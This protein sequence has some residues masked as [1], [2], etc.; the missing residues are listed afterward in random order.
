MRH[1]LALLPLL[2]GC[3]LFKLAAIEKGHPSEVGELTVAGL[4]DTVVI[5][6]DSLG[7]PH[8][9]AATAD[10]AI[11]GLGFVHAQDRLFQADLRRRL[12]WGQLSPWLGEDLA[13][14]DLFNQ[15]LELRDRAQRSI[16]ALPAEDRASVEAYVAGFNAGAASL[17]ALPIEYRLL[18]IDFEEWTAADTLSTPFLQ[19]WNLAENPS[20]E[21]FAYLNRAVL[22]AADAE[23]LFRHSLEGVPTEASWDDLRARDLPG[24]SEGYLSYTS[25]VGGMPSDPAGAQASNSWVIGPDKSAD[26]KPIV[27]NDPHLGQGVPSLWY[28]ADIKGGD[29]HVAGVTL[30]GVPGVVIGHNGKIAWGLTN[31]MADTVDLAVLERKGDQVVVDGVAETPRVVSTSAAGQTG[32]THWTSLGPIVSAPDPD[33]AVVLQWHALGIED[34]AFVAWGELNRATSVSDALAA[35]EGRTLSVAQNLVVGDVDGDFGWQQVGSV[36]ERE[37]HSGRVPHDGSSGDARWVG[38]H[39]DLPGERAPD[40][41][42][43]ITANARP[44]IGQTDF[45]AFNVP[46]WRHSRIHQLLTAGEDLTSADMTAIQMDIV[47]NQARTYLPGL[48]HEVSP[49]TP[50]ATTCHG[51]L[52]DWDGVMAT[53]S[54]GAAAWAAYQRELARLAAQAHFGPESADQLVS[55]MSSGRNLLDG[56]WDR[57]APD[58]TATSEAALDAACTWLTEKL[59]DD[60]EAWRWGDLH[61]LRLQHPFARSSKL[62]SKW[63]MAEVPWPG[64]GS[65]VAAAGYSWR[66]DDWKVGGMVSMRLVMPLGD[67][68][69]STLV[70][71]GGQSGHPRHPTYASH[72]EAFTT[73]EVLPLWF[74]DEDVIAETK[75]TLVLRPGG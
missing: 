22:S 26:G 29:L 21:A 51:L 19:S 14:L 2:T 28:A 47:D 69:A 71:P 41:G 63:N 36:V 30:A 23:A 56:D 54:A 25:A 15:G 45:G 43:I 42:F 13:T 59:G 66:R 32:E 9:R 61:P 75:A 27:A 10:D 1:T 11:Y 35:F 58:R 40:R 46:A 20:T 12:A 48:L 74:E 8:I 64:N 73:G 7:V 49:S 33:T 16:D 70:H 3:A 17:P 38:T 39:D 44:D 24:F 72:Y 68:G 55:V 4:G 31:V 60:P 6:R 65:T 50:A 5:H 34:Q 67:L 62:L 37:G 18:G 52:A 57:F 53:D